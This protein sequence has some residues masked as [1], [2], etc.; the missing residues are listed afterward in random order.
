MVKPSRKVNPRALFEGAY[1]KGFDS[2]NE[3]FKGKPS[4]YEVTV[5]YLGLG[6]DITTRYG[7]TQV[8]RFQR[9]GGSETTLISK[10]K[11]FAEMVQKHLDPGM[12][13]GLY[14]TPEGF[15]A[16]DLV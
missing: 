2:L 13:L 9:E 16:F 8:Y 7:E 5:T 11:V 4:E 15:W 12:K 1:K 3:E 10:S 14:K 6:D